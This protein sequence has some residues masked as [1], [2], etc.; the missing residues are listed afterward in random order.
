MLVIATLPPD[1][2]RLLHDRA[3]F[4]RSHIAVDDCP[5]EHGAI[6]YASRDEIRADL[7]IIVAWQPPGAAAWTRVD[8]HWCWSRACANHLLSQP[9][10]GCR[11]GFDTRPSCIAGGPRRTS[12]AAS[13]AAGRG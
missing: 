5:E 9:A 10:V 12:W 13:F 4:T 1:G 7:R 2:P 3:H 8:G 6:M 11:G